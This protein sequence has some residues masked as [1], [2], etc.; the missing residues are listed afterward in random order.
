[1]SRKGEQGHSKTESLE[2]INQFMYVETPKGYQGVH[3][4]KPSG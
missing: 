1:M 4:V 3:I 2:F